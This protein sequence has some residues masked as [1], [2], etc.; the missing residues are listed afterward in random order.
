MKTKFYIITRLNADC[1]PG[2]PQLQKNNLNDKWLKARLELLVNYCCPSVFNQSWKDFQFILWCHPET[3][4]IWKELLLMEP[5]E[6]VNV[7][8]ADSVDEAIDWDADIIVTTRLDSDDLIH[9]DFMFYIRDHLDRFIASEQTRQVY[10][11]RHGYRYGS[12]AGPRGTLH[13]ATQDDAPFL[14]LFSDIREDKEDA[15]VYHDRHK[16]MLGLHDHVINKTLPAWISVTHDDQIA[17][18]GVGIRALADITTT[19]AEFGVKK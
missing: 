19:F 6:W 12:L 16:R 17:G 18:T 10:A 7:I 14:T 1:F 15:L 4:A 5:S 13:N 8:F 3:P 11:F 2:R 9:R